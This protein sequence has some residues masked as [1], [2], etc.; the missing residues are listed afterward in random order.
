MPSPPS[1]THSS[2]KNCPAFAQGG[3]AEPTTARAAFGISRPAALA[4]RRPR[5]YNQET[6]GAVSQ[7]AGAIRHPGPV[8]P[9]G[10][11]SEDS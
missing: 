8:T 3:P 10:H 2:S 6:V 9:Q 5:W 7:P 4:L 11:T 1:M